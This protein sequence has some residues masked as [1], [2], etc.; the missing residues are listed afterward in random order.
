MADACGRDTSVIV[1]NV[2]AYFA[3]IKAG[4]YKD[5]YEQLSSVSKKVYPLNEFVA[6]HSGNRM[7]VQDIRVDDVVFN[8]YDNKKAVVTIS[9]P[10]LIYGQD[11]LPLEVL[12]EEDG[13]RI[14]LSKSIVENRTPR[15]GGA[16]RETANKDGKKG[17]AVS[18]FFKKIF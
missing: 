13:W 11:T 14:V 18:G 10:F 9:S 8:R 16:G 1:K 4:D 17:G 15:S 12:R 3:E 6:A 7:K 5:A 2:N